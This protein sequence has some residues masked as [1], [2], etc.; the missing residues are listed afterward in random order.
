MIL[1]V[2]EGVWELTIDHDHEPARFGS[3][4]AL[5]ES[6]SAEQ[7]GECEVK[8]TARSVV[9]LVAVSGGLRPRAL[10]GGE[11]VPGSGRQ[12]S[13]EV[14]HSGD[15][16]LGAAADCPSLSRGRP[17]VAGLPLEFAHAVVDGLVRVTCA[18]GL[19]AG[20][21]SIDRAAHD[22][23]D[24]SPI[25]FERAAGVLRCVLASVESSGA[26]DQDE[27]RQLLS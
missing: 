26:L 5:R 16:G 20:V 27:I 24:S 1:Q 8:R 3:I 7:P 25:A 15:L 4:G 22:E 21:L 6:I 2:R 19:P 23:V 9:E 18:T 13:I 12:V 10:I 11:F 17:L 14:S